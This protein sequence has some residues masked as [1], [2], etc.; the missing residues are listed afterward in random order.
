M[1]FIFAIPFDTDQFLSKMVATF[2]N[3]V[4]YDT[5]F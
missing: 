3:N 1:T 5:A 4:F 2:N